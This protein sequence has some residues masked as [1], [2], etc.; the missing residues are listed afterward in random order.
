MTHLA[1]V[2]YPVYYFECASLQRNSSSH[3][4]QNPDNALGI[5]VYPLRYIPGSGA[6]LAMRRWLAGLKAA[7]LVRKSQIKNPI[8]WFYHPM[9]FA[10]GYSYADS[11][12]VY[13]VTQNFSP[14]EADPTDFYF[15]ELTIIAEADIVIPDSTELEQHVKSLVAD[16]AQD[17]S[18]G[19]PSAD[20]HCLLAPPCESEWATVAGEIDAALMRNIEI[21]PVP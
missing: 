20:I 14:G 5:T 3:S 6:G 16:L 1:R 4:S 8:L 9:L 11:A 15:E 21:M 13:E 12:I 10:M 17:G 18:Y 7:R 2:G 19:V